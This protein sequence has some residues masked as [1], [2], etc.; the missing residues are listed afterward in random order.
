MGKI[1]ILSCHEHE[2]I[3][4]VKSGL[5]FSLLYRVDG[6]EFSVDGEF[7]VDKNNYLHH[8]HICTDGT[9]LDIKVKL[10]D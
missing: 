10:N 4:L 1:K 2:V 7:F 6:E 8:Q 9:E 3:D 5:G